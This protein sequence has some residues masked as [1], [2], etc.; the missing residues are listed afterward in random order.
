MCA[1]GTQGFAFGAFQRSRHFEPAAERWRDLARR[2]RLGMVLA[3]FPDDDPPRPRGSGLPVFVPLAP[4][5]PLRE[6]WAVV[7]DSPAFAAVLTAWEVPGQAGRSDRARE[8][9]AVWT[10]DPAPA[11]AAGQ[12]CLD[13]AASS[14]VVDDVGSLSAGLAASPLAAAAS[15]R[16][17]TEFCD[18]VIGHLDR[19]DTGGR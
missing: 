2:S 7:C 17:V 16:G 19:R 9:E 11:R 4:D 14:G 5:A 10:L 6:E 15:P 3:E 13:I 18:R 12:V 1:R 8:F